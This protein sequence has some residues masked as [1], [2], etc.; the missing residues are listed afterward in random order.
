LIK[1][2][3]TP[4]NL[5][6][7]LFLLTAETFAAGNPGPEQSL[8]ARRVQPV[9]YQR[10]AEDMAV[11]FIDVGQGLSILVESPSGARLLYDAGGTPE[12]MNSSWDPGLQIVVPYLEE[13]RIRRLDYA[14][15]SHAHGDHIG[16][17]K[18][19]LYNYKIGEFLDPGYAYS[20]MIYKSLLETVM[21]M[22]IKYR[23]AGEGD[24]GDIKLGN[25]IQCRIFSPPKE[26]HFQGTDSDCNNSSIIMKI[27]YKNVSFLFTGDA[28][29][30][31]ELYA[32]K[33]YGSEL[34]SNVLQV[35]HHGSYTSSSKIFLD[36]V[37]PE[38]A[39]ISVGT[40]NTFGHP[41]PEALNNLE[42]AGAEI[43]RTDYDGN[44]IIYT[45]GKTFTVETE[46]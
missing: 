26:Y 5:F 36:C 30:K 43:F 15:M 40:N 41:H 12:W 25:D 39:V 3:K 42:N 27:T 18:A 38:V 1:R 29:A 33:K 34:L 2:E 22:K 9:K 10:S 45:N 14:V 21:T 37:V 46:K 13:R 8:V 24:G 11:T 17:Y 31:A 20:T 35:G 6:I 23:V 44:V 16:G 19:V 32:A 7:L 28:E 4:F